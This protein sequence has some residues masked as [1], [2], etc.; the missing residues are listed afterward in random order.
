MALSNSL[1]VSITKLVSGK[2][3]VQ[4]IT[5]AAAPIIARL[6]SP[7]D[8]GVRQI[9]MS[10][11]SVIGVITCL[12]YELS[13][14]LARD[15]KEASASFTL[16]LFLTI[17]FT[18][19]VLTMVPVI[20]GKMAQWFKSPEL[21]VFLWLLPGV[22]FI[23]GLVKSLRYWAAREGR[24]GAMAW[25]DFGAALSGRLTMIVWALIIG[26]SAAGL[27]AGYVIGVIFSILLLLLFLSRKLISD[28]NNAHLNFG[29]LWTTAK[30]HKK[31]PIFSTW[32]GLLNAVSAQLP[33]IILGLYFSTT[34]VGYYSLGYRLVSLPVGLLGG[35]IAQVFFPAA[36]KEYNETGTLSEIVSNMFKRLVQIG[37]FPLVA[38]GFLGASLFSVIFGEKWIEAGIYAQILSSY[39]MCQFVSSPLS[40]ICSI[41]QR[42][43][44]L[45]AWN[46]VFAFCRLLGLSLGARTGKPLIALLLYNIAGIIAYS[47]LTVWI[48]RNS[49]ISLRWGGKMFLKYLGLSCLLLLP[50]GY[51]AYTWG[52]IFIVLGSL[53][54]A[55]V[56]YSYNLYRQDSSFQE[57]VANIVTGRFP[58]GRWNR[59][60]VPK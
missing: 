7:D 35:S 42:Q 53:G 56:I 13:I 43:G 39:L 44:T 31:F 19:A 60:E 52:N 54:L 8:F 58:F 34:V 48:L 59:K 16:S 6:F 57:A 17:V 18:L 51:L 5:L 38:L 33:T 40:A 10:I 12:R 30:H 4:V 11:A 15:E 29:T 23:G 45:L 46:V 9:F 28:I 50:V 47:F 37:V 36:A 3:A 1:G 27:L 22:V 32:S 20:K 55:T 14:P 41:L 25:S 21:D 24:F 49:R 2:V 26:A